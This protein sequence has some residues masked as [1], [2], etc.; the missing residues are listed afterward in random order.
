ML[1][2]IPGVSQAVAAVIMSEY[3]SIQHLIETIS[4]NPLAL[5]VLTIANKTGKTR[6]VA[7]PAI[8][9]I[10]AYLLNAAV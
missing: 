7:K 8:Q 2:Q 1:M 3:K 6:K 5:N 9:N 10:Y 4:K